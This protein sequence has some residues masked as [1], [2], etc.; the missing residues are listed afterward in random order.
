M[1]TAMAFGTI[2]A[3]SSGKYTIISLNK[4]NMIYLITTTIFPFIL[5]LHSGRLY[6]HSIDTAKSNK[7][8]R[9]PP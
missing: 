5:S 8:T 3:G 7:D 9:F 1:Y 2:P 4:F 6:Y